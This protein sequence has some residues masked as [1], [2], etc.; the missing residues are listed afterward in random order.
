MR[1]IEVT[2]SEFDHEKK[3]LNLLWEEARES[4]SQKGF[5]LPTFEVFWN[6]EPIEV[7]QPKKQQILLESFRA[8]PENNPLNTP[9]GKIEIFSKTIDS[10]NYSD[11]AGFPK[12][13]T[14]KE[15]LGSELANKYPLHLI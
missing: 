7:L 3:W 10:Y 8:N 14:P 4:A 2:K 1:W 9:S 11:C 5:S 6:G 15:W 13:F 12:W